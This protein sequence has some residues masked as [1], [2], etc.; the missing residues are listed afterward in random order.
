MYWWRKRTMLYLYCQLPHNVTL[1]EIVSPSCEAPGSE[2]NLKLEKHWERGLSL[3]NPSVCAKWCLTGRVN[4]WR[5]G[6]SGGGGGGGVRCGFSSSLEWGLVETASSPNYVLDY[7]HLSCRTVSRDF[8]PLLF[9]SKDSTW[10]P[11]ERFCGPFSFS[12]RFSIF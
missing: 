4:G 3:G 7:H 12:R 2:K 5:Y 8:R 1:I 9:C 11:Y 10:A 6:Y